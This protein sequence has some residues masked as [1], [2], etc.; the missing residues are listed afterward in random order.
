MATARTPTPHADTLQ[1]CTALFEHVPDDRH[2]LLW[3]LPDKASTWI[4]L[5]VGETDTDTGPDRMAKAAAQLTAG[6]DVYVGCSVARGPGKREQ[7]ITSA[8]ATGMVGLWADIDI[9]DPDVHKKFNLPPDEASAR[10]LLAS[11]GLVPSVLVWSGHGLQAWWLFTEFW[12]FDSTEARMAAAD[13]AMRWNDTLRIRAAERNWTVD[14]TFDLARVMRVPGT[15]NRKGATPEQVRLLDSND[16]RYEP[17]D[18]AAFMLDDGYLQSRGISAAR[19]YV[20]GKDLELSEAATY[21]SEKFEVLMENIDTF[22]ATWNRKRKDFQDDSAN[23]YDA[24]L[25][26]AAAGAGWTDSEIAALILRWR[27]RHNAQPDK[28][29]RKDYI[30]RTIGLA[31]DSLARDDAGEQLE[32]AAQAVTDA[33]SNGDDDDLRTARRAVLDSLSAQLQVEVTRIIRYTSEPPTFA[34]VTPAATIPV[35]G[36]DGILRHEKLLQRIWET[37]GLQIPTFSKA[38]WGR[39][40]AVIPASWE[41]QD[42]GVESTESGQLHAWISGY[43]SMQAPI[44]DVAVAVKDNYPFI[45]ADSGGIVILGDAFRRWL[46]LQYQERLTNATMGR[47]LRAFGC[48]PDRINTTNESGN[49]SSRSIWR[50]PADWHGRVG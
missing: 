21:D 19:S 26:R 17:D 39:I 7:R 23:V 1:F 8:N 33:K 43:L 2:T 25:A 35:G 11:C 48:T 50:L 49:R 12:D 36:A 20:V 15:L 32:D 16:L 46:W 3:T 6:H 9:A 31:R 34:L 24:A 40:T 28:A 18:F 45:D 27:R 30:A 5:H 47:R 14:S 38:A 37:I 22:R 44:D 4:D 29:L 41:D 10:E 42:V 13:L